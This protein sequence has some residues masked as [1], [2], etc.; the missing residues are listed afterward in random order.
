MLWLIYWAGSFSSRVYLSSFITLMIFS[1]WASLLCT[2]ACKLGHR[3]KY[4]YSIGCPTCGRKGGRT[5]HI[6]SIVGIAIDKIK[7]EA[8][9]PTRIS[10]LV[11]AW[12]HKK[13]AIKR[14]IPSLVGLLQHTTKIV[15]SGRTFVSY[16][17]ATAV[18]L[19]KCTILQD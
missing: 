11:D 10:H 9:L 13:S 4:L 16:M 2:H 3:K 17:Y 19:E 1:Q 5:N 7:M 8:H 15:H 18:K 12:L 6:S 14:E